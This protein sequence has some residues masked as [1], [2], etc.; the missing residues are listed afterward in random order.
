MESSD[1]HLEMEIPG[2]RP[3]EMPPLHTHASES[4]LQGGGV[5]RSISDP[6]IF[7][8]GTSLLDVEAPDLAS[9]ADGAPRAPRAEAAEAQV[10]ADAQERE[11]ASQNEGPTA[12]EIMQESNAEPLDIKETLTALDSYVRGQTSD[13]HA[14]AK[15]KAQLYAAFRVGCWTVLLT[16]P[17]TIWPVAEALQ[18][19]FASR[20]GCQAHARDLIFS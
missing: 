17:I 7:T 10:D 8:T 16:L 11:A 3:G 12:L 20:V 9:E 6:C 19:G 5:P 2:E 18:A 14:R 15:F 13:S 1:E 4:S